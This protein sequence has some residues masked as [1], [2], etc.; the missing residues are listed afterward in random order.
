MGI[1]R[2]EK[3][4]DFHGGG[5]QLLVDCGKAAVYGLFLIECP[6]NRLTGEYLLH[7]TVDLAEK[8]LLGTE[9]LL[10]EFDDQ[11]DQQGGD[12]KNDQRDQRHQRGDGKH[13]IEHTNNGSRRGNELGNALAHALAQCT[14]SLVI[15]ESTS[16]TV[17]FSKYAMGR[18]WDLLGDFPAHP[19]ADLLTDTGP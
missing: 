9:I 7:L 18:R 17:R 16:P 14:T 5:V 4:W 6:Y 19:V 13:H 10:A 11:H 8:P 12:R 3:N 1:I 15:R 2:P